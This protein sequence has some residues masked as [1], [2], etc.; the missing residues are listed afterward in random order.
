MSISKRLYPDE[1]HAKRPKLKINDVNYN[2]NTLDVNSNSTLGI[3][4]INTKKW[5]NFKR[6][7]A[8]LCYE[9]KTL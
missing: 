3:S 9:F 7:T 8:K 2:G 6:Y 4:C 1:E 5:R